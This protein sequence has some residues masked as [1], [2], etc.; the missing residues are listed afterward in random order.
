MKLKK[1]EQQIGSIDIR[2]FMHQ[3][4]GVV[5]KDI[6]K[7][8]HE[9]VSD[10]FPHLRRTSFAHVSKNPE[11][12]RYGKIV[13]VKDKNNNLAPYITPNTSHL[14]ENPQFDIGILIEHIIS[15]LKVTAELSESTIIVIEGEKSLDGLI[16]KENQLGSSKNLPQTLIEITNETDIDGVVVTTTG[17]VQ[18]I[19]LKDDSLEEL[20]SKTDSVAIVL[21]E[22]QSISFISNGITQTDYDFIML[23]AGLYITLALLIDEDEEVEIE[24]YDVPN[25][26]ELQ[27]MSNY[28]LVSLMRSYKFGQQNSIYYAIRRELK[29]RKL[30]EKNKEKNKQK[31]YKGEE[32]K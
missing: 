24:L 6:G 10:F 3:Y 25:K 13:L 20:S 5:H 7:M 27:T 16:D 9:V 12:L 15:S 14:S 18:K 29:R 17:D 11:L 22:D 28:Q 8:T 31:I 30:S 26:E 32:F 23:R 4:Y 2:K 19:R 21:E 1:L